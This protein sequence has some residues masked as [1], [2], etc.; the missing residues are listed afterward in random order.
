M[1]PESQPPSQPPLRVL[2]IDGERERAS[3]LEDTLRRE[4]YVILGRL[5]PGPD[6][7]AQVQRLAPDAI[8][9]DMAAPDRDSLE[10]MRSISREQ[11]KPIVMFVDTDDSSF[12]T[13]AIDAG[14]TAYVVDGVN[15]QRV[16][17]LLEV[18][19]A[20]FRQFDKIRSE[21]AQAKASLA[22]RKQVERAKG[23]IM[24]QRGCTEEEAYRDLRK[25]AMDRNMRIADVAASVLAV[26]KLL[27]K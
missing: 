21:L 26:A 23:L 3:T 13:Q 9:I 11:P 27:D 6:L 20:Q 5:T 14:V 4:G 19:I 15:P 17:M 12:L 18:A 24:Q 8:V 25:L 16:R 2:L 1:G 7:S 22:E 10:H